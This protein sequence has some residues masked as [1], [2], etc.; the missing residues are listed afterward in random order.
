M[1]GRLKKGSSLEQGVKQFTVLPSVRALELAKTA[2]SGRRSLLHRA[3]C[4]RPTLNGTDG[5]MT[6]LEILL[7][8]ALLLIVLG[9]TR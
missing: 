5:T 3:C 1:I 2:P 4:A 9:L 6:W 8:I 7:A